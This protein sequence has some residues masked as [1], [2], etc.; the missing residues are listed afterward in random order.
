MQRQARFP[1]Y[2]DQIAKNTNS[3]FDYPLPPLEMKTWPDLGTLSFDHPRTPPPL[4]IE[5]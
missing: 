2:F 1:E 4:K 5:I 3:Q